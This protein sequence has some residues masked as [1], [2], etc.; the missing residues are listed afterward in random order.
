MAG[1]SVRPGPP[2]FA[3]RV[4]AHQVVAGGVFA[5]W[6]E[7]DALPYWDDTGEFEVS[8]PDDQVGALNR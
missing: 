2:G 8:M 5:G 7:P 3:G 6:Q 4:L 1:L